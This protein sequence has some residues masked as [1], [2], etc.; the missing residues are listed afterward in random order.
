LAAVTETAARMFEKFIFNRMTARQQV[1]YLRK[2]GIILGTRTK[3]GRKIHIYMLKD[4]FIEV[5]YQND[6]ADLEAEKV[7]ILEGLDNLN[8]YLEKEFRAS[9]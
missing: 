8:S 1:N 9:F 6:N 7:S 4:L 2:K 5:L 3:E